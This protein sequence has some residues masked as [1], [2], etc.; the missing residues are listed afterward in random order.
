MAPRH[1]IKCPL[2]STPK[3]LLW[4]PSLIW[5]AVIFRLS[6]IPGADLP[7]TG[8][9]WLAH[10]I[11]YLILSALIFIAVRPDTNPTTAVCLAILLASA[12]GVTDEI[13]Q[14]FVPNRTPDIAD[15]GFDTIGA[16]I[17]AWLSRLMETKIATRTK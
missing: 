14:S 3:T 16:A 2:R 10:I 17:G 8:F 11:V 6:S 4:I 12:Y 15:W 5:A 13:H 9:D 1:M 7:P